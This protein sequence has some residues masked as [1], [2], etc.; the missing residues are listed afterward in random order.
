MALPAAHPDAFAEAV[1]WFRK[2]IPMTDEEFGALEEQNY[3]RAF[4]VAGLAQ[5]DMV[6]Q[7]YEAVDRAIAQGESLDSF[8]AALT[9]K[10]TAAWGKEMPW[11]IETI[12]RT[13]TQQ[14]YSDGR[15]E[16]LEHPA[17]KK[18]RPFR[19]FSAVMDSRTTE[20]CAALDDTVLP[21]DDPFW[22]KHNPPLHFNCRSHV[23]SLS[24]SEAQ[25]EG[26][27]PEPPP[28]Q[29]MDGFGVA[30]NLRDE[31][32]DLTGYPHPLVAEYRRAS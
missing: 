20:I 11:R 4:R 19:R 27:D 28:E 31:Q 18:A 15:Y 26:I 9:D 30:P 23:V 22:A 32:P 21:A 24:E 25:D 5:L 13:N 1:A 14:A 29:P 16:Q 6:T 3:H 17:V 10:L 2:R 8:R 12:L 7:V